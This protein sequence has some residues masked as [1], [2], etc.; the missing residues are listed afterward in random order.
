[1]K[2][3]LRDYKI[4]CNSAYRAN[5]SNPTL[6]WSPVDGF[7]TAPSRSLVPNEDVRIGLAY[8][9]LNNGSKRSLSGSASEYKPIA[10][11]IREAYATGDTNRLQI[12]ALICAFQH[13]YTESD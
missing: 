8:Y 5:I 7:Y 12:E 13:E 1:M 10:H 2:L 11:A 6:F 9:D 3:S 4:A